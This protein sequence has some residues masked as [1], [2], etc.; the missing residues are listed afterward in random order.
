MIITPSKT[1]FNIRNRTNVTIEFNVSFINEW[2]KG[3]NAQNVSFAIDFLNIKNNITFSS[4]NTY[5][6]DILEAKYI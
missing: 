1:Q 6:S 5:N 2:N 4:N 3:V